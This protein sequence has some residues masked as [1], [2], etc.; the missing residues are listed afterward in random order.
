MQA[1]N[2][3][4]SL[5]VSNRKF[6][7]NSKENYFEPINYDS[8]IIINESSPST[9]TVSFRLPISQYFYKAFDVLEKKLSNLDLNKIHNNLKLS[10][11]VISRENL[12]M[13]I[14]KVT[15]N[16]NVIKKTYLNIDNELISH[17]H[18]KSISNNIL[19][20][21]NDT[22]NEISPNVYLVKHSQDNGQL[23]RCKIYLKKCEYYYFSNNNLADLLGGELV[24]DKKVYQY[25]GKILDFKKINNIMEN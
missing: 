9:T 6:Y 2:S 4:H 11:V 16:L 5:S 8:N 7:W 20:K 15:S 23:Q 18:F 22:L 10:G 21:F 13:K 1:T 14:N 19:T 12:N 25:L 24:L 17:N 3:H